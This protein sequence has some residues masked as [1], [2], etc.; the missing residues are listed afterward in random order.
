MMSEPFRG[1]INK[2]EQGKLA[3]SFSVLSLIKKV[4]V[5]FF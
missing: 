1:R 5:G 3:I 2:K 4:T